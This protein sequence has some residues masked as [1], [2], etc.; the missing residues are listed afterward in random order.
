MPK[1]LFLCLRVLRGG[2]F[3]YDPFPPVKIDDCG[4]GLV[5]ICSKDV[6]QSFTSFAL[7]IFCKA[8]KMKMR[9]NYEMRV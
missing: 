9:G 1:D 3:L 6:L 2:F 8:C 4:G 7:Y 5:T